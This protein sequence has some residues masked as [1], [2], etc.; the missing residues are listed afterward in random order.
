MELERCCECDN[1]TACVIRF[2]ENFGPDQYG[3]KRCVGCARKYI[4]TKIEFY[5]A[6]LLQINKSYAYAK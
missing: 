1:L 4:Q 5:T 6:C 3:R 2:D